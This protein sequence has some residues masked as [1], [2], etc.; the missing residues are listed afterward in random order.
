MR[1]RHVRGPLIRPLGPDGSVEFS[2]GFIGST[3]DFQ[4]GIHTPLQLLCY[5]AEGP[6]PPVQNAQTLPIIVNSFIP[7]N[8]SL[9]ALSNAL[10]IKVPTELEDLD[11]FN[12]TLFRIVVMQVLN[13]NNI[14][15]IQ[16]NNLNTSVIVTACLVERS[17]FGF[18]DLRSTV[19]GSGEICTAKNDNCP[20]HVNKCRCPGDF[21]QQGRLMVAQ[22]AQNLQLQIEAMVTL[23]NAPAFKPTSTQ[24]IIN[25]YQSMQY[26]LVDSLSQ[27]GNPI[28]KEFKVYADTI[29]VSEV[30]MS[31]IGSTP[32]PTSRFIEATPRPVTQSPS[33]AS[34]LTFIKEVLAVLVISVFLLP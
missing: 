12:L 2:V 32:K 17:T 19:C 25:T 21:Q 34:R 15:F 14:T 10:I 18:A 27:P 5:C 4:T 6:C 16:L 30:N 33:S 8:V 20:P 23:E 31:V 28:W 29:L 3:L 1:H 11:T 9:N 13:Q 7:S 26:A 22:Q 24:A